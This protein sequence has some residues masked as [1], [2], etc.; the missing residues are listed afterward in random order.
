MV[1][2]MI[3]GFEV[4]L[5]TTALPQQKAVMNQVLACL[6]KASNGLI[7]APTATGKT[8]ALLCSSLAWLQK[9]TS[10]ECSLQHQNTIAVASGESTTKKTRIIYSASTDM[11][12]A[13]A[14]SVVNR[15]HYK[16]M[17]SVIFTSSDQISTHLPNCSIVS[18]IDKCLGE[19]AS[20]RFPNKALRECKM[21]PNY[22]DR[23]IERFEQLVNFEENT[24]WRFSAEQKSYYFADI[25]FVSH[26]Y[27]FN[28]LLIEDKE[29]FKDSVII[30]DEAHDIAETVEQVFSTELTY[31]TLLNCSNKLE[32]FL[33]HIKKTDKYS[34][35][36]LQANRLHNAILKLKEEIDKISFAN[37][38][39]NQTLGW[40][41]DVLKKANLV[42]TQPKHSQQ[43]MQN[44]FEF[45]EKNFAS[46]VSNNNNNDTNCFNE[47]LCFLKCVHKLNS[48]L[49][50]KVKYEAF[51]VLISKQ[52]KSNKNNALTAWSLK[53]W[54]L[55]P[56]VGMK[57]LNNLEIHSCIFTSSVLL[58]ESYFSIEMDSQFPIKLQNSKLG[59]HLEIYIIGEDEN[60]RDLCF[61]ENSEKSC[62]YLSLASTVPKLCNEIPSGVFLFFASEKLMKECV[63][64]WQRHE[65]II[66]EKINSR[67]LLIIDT[68]TSDDI[69]EKN[70]RNIKDMEGDY[71]VIGVCQKKLINRL[72][73]SDNLCRAIILVGLP[74]P[75]IEPRISSK[76]EYL[77]KLNCPNLT[78]DAWY[79]N[80]MM[81][82]VTLLIDKIITHK[83][84]FGVVI[85]C[86]SR[87]S[88][89]TDY[90]PPWT[91]PI[92]FEQPY[93][94]TFLSIR[95]FFN[96][97][98]SP[99]PSQTQTLANEIGAKLMFRDQF[100][101]SDFELSKIENFKSKILNNEKH[102]LEKPSTSYKQ[103]QFESMVE[104]KKVDE[105]NHLNL[106]SFTKNEASKEQ[107]GLNRNMW[108]NFS[109]EL[110]SLFTNTGKFNRLCETIRKYR[111][112]ENLDF[113]INTLIWI[114]SGVRKAERTKYLIMISLVI[115]EEKD[116]SMD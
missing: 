42:S 107:R 38:N 94:Q 64:T 31:Q 60:G 21:L 90:L 11:L 65:H 9:Q 54:C 91:K 48:P 111:K 58:N 43:I 40:F 51:K 66:Q 1:I 105:L 92:I 99:A 13:E 96:R 78:P 30:I 4:V 72:K 53:V 10:L 45:I 62:H 55:S 87:F 67:K 18:T 37:N 69:F 39:N 102:L 27:L 82:S 25:I 114:F 44:M 47:F 22:A 110:K 52:K 3:A 35:L 17:D 26:T 113:F 76:K 23:V 81:V 36:F 79:I 59:S 57:I 32:E 28:H 109:E 61:R 116:R 49:L 101:N 71:L 95:S 70:L 7:V 115:S 103:S 100:I 24:F 34:S 89:K 15:T 74:Y 97:L 50:Q 84:D 33:I 12:L 85:L 75:S 88:N 63:A 46:S 86:D 68:T 19:L 20:K 73:F 104:M 8:L 83:N 93:Y 77:K 80:K 16:T 29:L 41:F 2:E 108:K 6:K 14:M 56:S 112:Y 5:P 106:P 98:L